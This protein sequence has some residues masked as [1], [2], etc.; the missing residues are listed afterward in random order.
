M[1]IAGKFNDNH[2]K[3]PGV[4]VAARLLGRMAGGDPKGALKAFANVMTQH[5]LNVGRTYSNA[6]LGVTNTKVTE[7]PRLDR[8][9]LQMPASLLM[10]F[11]QEAKEGFRE[12]K[13]VKTKRQNAKP[14]PGMQFKPG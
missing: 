11:A 2:Q 3:R 12:G 6:A 7:V 14:S 1:A 4:L 9:P 10:Q 5:V 13:A 8:V